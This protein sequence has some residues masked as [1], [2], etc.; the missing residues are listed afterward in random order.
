[1]SKQQTAVPHFLRICHWGL[2]LKFLEC[3]QELLGCCLFLPDRTVTNSN[4]KE[5]EIKRP[6]SREDQLQVLWIVCEG[7]N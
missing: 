6:F 4:E 3:I 1:M 5:L 2:L 7:M